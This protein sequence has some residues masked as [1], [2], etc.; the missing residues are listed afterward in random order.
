MKASNALI[1]LLLSGVAVSVWANGQGGAD[2]IT[3]ALMRTLGAD[4]SGEAGQ[5]GPHG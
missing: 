4:Q 5:D 1:I 2:N 3:V